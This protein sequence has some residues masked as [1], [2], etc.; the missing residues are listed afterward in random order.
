[1][2]SRVRR[3]KNAEHAIEVLGGVT[4]IAKLL[5][6]KRTAVANWLHRG[7]PPE[8][9]I[10]LGRRLRKLRYEYDEYKL[11]KQYKATDDEAKP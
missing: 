10:E 5:G 6:K 1:M 2:P 7:L 3:I 4:E 8:A 9:C 11:F